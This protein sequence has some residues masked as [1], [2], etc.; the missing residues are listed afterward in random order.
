V[1][2]WRWHLGGVRSKQPI[3]YTVAISYEFTLSSFVTR[4]QMLSELTFQARLHELIIS[5]AKAKKTEEPLEFPWMVDGAGLPANASQ[6]LPKM[7]KYF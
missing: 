1:L 6:L 4:I 5:N 7:V 3:F 2:G